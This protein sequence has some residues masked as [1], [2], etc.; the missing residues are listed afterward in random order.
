MQTAFTL[1]LRSGR[2]KKINVLLALAA[3]SALAG[4]SAEAAN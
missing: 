1:P 2:L 4:A 3:T